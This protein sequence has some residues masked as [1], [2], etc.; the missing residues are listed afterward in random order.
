M[1]KLIIM[2]SIVILCITM[3]SAEK[4]N[5]P[6]ELVQGCNNCTYCNISKIL[7]PNQTVFLTNLEMTEDGESYNYTLSNDYV[8]IRGEYCWWY[9]CGN[10]DES[11]TGKLC[12]EVTNTGK[13]VTTAEGII[14]MISFAVLL[15][16]FGI[17]LYF[18][19]TI[20]FSNERKNKKLIRINKYKYLKIICIET[21]YIL[22]TFL[23]A[24][25]MSMSENLLYF[26]G[27]YNLFYFL[28]AVLI[29][30]L[31]PSVFFI[32]GLFIYL[33][34]ADGKAA[35]RLNDRGRNLT[36]W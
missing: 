4:I 13:E 22:L 7:Y 32:V 9:V 5:E 34:T 28:Y 15:T 8:Q 26:N 19:V 31:I 29:N 35:K 12:F 6:V 36:R 25:A 17:S 10:A 33:K 27:V 2:T 14:Y 3:I 1:K 30:L 11:D 24:L 16:F 20:P 21:T 23:T 18:A